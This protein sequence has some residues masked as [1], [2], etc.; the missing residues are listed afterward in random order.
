MLAALAQ[1]LSLASSLVRM[2]NGGIENDVS[3]LLQWGGL[4]AKAGE[5]GR[6]EL[7]EAT[8]KVQQLVDEDRGLTD[9]ENDALD[10]AIA[11]KLARAAA[12][13]LGSD[14]PQDPAPPGGDNFAGS[15]NEP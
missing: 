13:D 5:S 11:D 3:K 1:F 4:A 15:S 8:A 14:A 2:K 12:V 6:R 9:S 10:R 7:A